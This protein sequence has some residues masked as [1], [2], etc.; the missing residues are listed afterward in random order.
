MHANH[1]AAA[2][3]TLTSLRVCAIRSWTAGL[4]AAAEQQDGT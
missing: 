2:A 4:A 1:D 3:S